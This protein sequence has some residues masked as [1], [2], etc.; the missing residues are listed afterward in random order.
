MSHFS[1]SQ[2]DTFK[3]VYGL[4]GIWPESYHLLKLKHSI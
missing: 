1:S 2:Q 3:K 4:K